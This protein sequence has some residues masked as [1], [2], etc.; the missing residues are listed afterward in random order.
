MELG[1]NW[2]DVSILKCQH[3]DDV[4]L[5]FYVLMVSS[6]DQWDIQILNENFQFFVF[7]A[8]GFD[9]QMFFAVTSVLIHSR[10]KCIS[11]DVATAYCKET[12]RRTAE[13]AE[14]SDDAA[15]A[16]GRAGA[17]GQVDIPP[18]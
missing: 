14:S 11:A 17:R 15:R 7:L 12:G 4:D 2:T 16:V 9:M 8:G 18:G 1:L 10:T 5:G 6:I 13:T 3:S